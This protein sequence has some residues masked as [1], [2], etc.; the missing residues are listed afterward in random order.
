MKNLFLAAAMIPMIYASAQ[1]TDD[2]I[3]DLQAQI[4]EIRVMAESRQVGAQ[5]PA[6]YP[7]IED[8]IGL[9]FELGGMYQNA[10]L[11]A[12]EYAFVVP[13]VTTTISANFEG[14]MLLPEAKMGWGV[15]GS[16]SYYCKEHGYELKLRNSYFDLSSSSFYGV[17]V[18]QNVLFPLNYA[19]PDVITSIDAKAVSSSLGITY[20]L[21]GLELQKSFYVNRYFNIDVIG[22]LLASWNWLTRSSTYHEIYLFI[23]PEDPDWYLYRQDHSSW[24]GIGP[25]LGIN[26][27]FMLGEGFSVFF[28]NTGALMYGKFDVKYYQE[29]LYYDDLVVGNFLTH[30]DLKASDHRIMPYVQSFMGLAYE[31]FAG[32]DKNFLKIRA[33]YNTQ[34]FI[35]A[36]TMIRYDGDDVSQLYYRL[37][38]N[39]QTQGLLFDLAWSF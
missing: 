5:S 11:G 18:D 26:L 1:D 8:A 10:V 2:Q 35:S 24:F 4:Q 28:N 34:Y 36:N 30:T 37:N 29:C 32:E 3:K 38:E 15:N 7:K 23:E 21:L 33:G 31:F 22:G 6:G 19:D 20:D 39:L 14:E 12:T 25:E 13:N 9:R 17:N 16:V 27:N